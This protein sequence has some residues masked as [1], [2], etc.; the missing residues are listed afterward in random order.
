MSEVTLK[1]HEPPE[2]TERHVVWNSIGHGGRLVMRVGYCP[3]TL[4]YFLGLF[5]DAQKV[6]PDIRPE[7]AICS[8]VKKSD[9]CQ[10]FTLMII[11]IKGPKRPVEGF[12]EC[13]WNSLR[14][15]AY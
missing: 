10:S 6:V 15:E 8:K 2:H 12:T 5:Q 9:S 14:I 7:E 11:P 4:G 3:D 1:A 13:S